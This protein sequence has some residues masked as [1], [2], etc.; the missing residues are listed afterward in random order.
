MASHPSSGALPSGVQP[1]KPATS[2]ANLPYSGLTTSQVGQANASIFPSAGLL[3][4]GAPAEFTFVPPSGVAAGQL[5]FRTFLGYVPNNA[6]ALPVAAE[7]VQTLSVIHPAQLTEPAKAVG[8]DPQAAFDMQAMISSA[9]SGY[10]ADEKE[11]VVFACEV[12]PTAADQP[13]AVGEI[14]IW[15]SNKY[16]AIA[17]GLLTMA[18]LYIAAVAIRAS[19]ARTSRTRASEL[20]QKLALLERRPAVRVSSEAPELGFW[21]SFDPV[22][23]SADIFNRASLSQ[24]QILFFFLLAG[25]GVAFSLFRTG[26][27]SELSPSIVVLLGIPAAGAVANQA[28]NS[29]RDRFSVDNW[30]WLVS[31]HVLAVDD[32]GTNP[33]EW[34]D[35]LMTAG[36][37]DLY[38]LQAFGF[39]VIVGAAMIYSGFTHLETFKVPDTL[40]QVMGLSQVVFVGGRLTKP[41]DVGDADGL[42]TQLRQRAADLLT[43]AT[44]G[45]DVDANGKPLRAVDPNGAMNAIATIDAARVVAP[46]AVA[47]YEDTASETRIL[48]ER[49]TY[50][51]VVTD[52]LR[53]P[54]A[55]H[56]SPPPAPV[57]RVVQ[58]APAVDQAAPPAPEPA[59]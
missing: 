40:L 14:P 18:I 7:E 33:P 29:N 4:S 49:L 51:D 13:V 26:T 58:E 27:L 52:Q 53:D 30:A 46:N 12:G 59:P 1:Q 48:L 47:R 54:F 35:V 19:A 55:W 37:I 23:L 56:A 32:P 44:T 25:Y 17:I 57:A 16:W 34:R 11:L 38:K 39:S 24:L 6:G 8:A 31:H 28:M 21:R 36:Q 43:A 9:A 20:R 42:V 2:C 15:I 5:R 10:W 22:V 41:A 50:R 45:V 3:P